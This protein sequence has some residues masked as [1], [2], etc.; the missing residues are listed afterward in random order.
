MKRVLLVSTFAA[1]SAACASTATDTG[2][3]EPAES[4]VSTT[5]TTIE[6]VAAPTAY[7][8]AMD[9]VRKL[10]AAGN[11]QQAIDRIAQLLGRPELT[12][13]QKARALF[14]MAELQL[15]KGNNVFGAI[16]S[17]SELISDYPGSELFSKASSLRDI[18]RGEATSLNGLLQQGTL[19]PT[20]QFEALFRLGQHQKAA[21]LMLSRNLSP[22]NAYILDMYQIGYL[23]DDDTLT[24]P[25]YA[26]SEP[27]GTQRIVRFC[28]FGK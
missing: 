10:V 8:L 1:L 18:A 11:E 19:S 9:T 26:L 27:D 22:E 24:G 28:D 21:D 3:T 6:E 5:T 2:V 23:C 20:K 12:D 15:G 7:D 17:L 16:D 14:S 4:A 13:S 25:K